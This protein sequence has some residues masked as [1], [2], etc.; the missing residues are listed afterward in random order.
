MDLIQYLSVDALMA[1]IQ[2]KM[3]VLRKHHQISPKEYSHIRSF[4]MGPVDRPELVDLAVAL[5]A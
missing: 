4:M 2:G 3:Q 5:E 1:R